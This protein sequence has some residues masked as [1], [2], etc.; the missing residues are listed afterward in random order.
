[1]KR[2]I[3]CVFALLLAGSIFFLG[4]WAA[5]VRRDVVIDGVEVGG[6][7]YAEA[8][9]CVRE[10]LSRTPFVLH[11]PAGNFTPDL[12]YTDDLDELLRHAKK[13][14]EYHVTVRREL[15]DAEAFVEDVCR[16]KRHFSAG[17]KARF[18]KKWIFLHG[19]EGRQMV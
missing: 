8:G 17:C 13:G 7:T 5:K 16:E 15:P 9:R 10:G 11:T 14:G 2:V 18:F 3:S 1:M 19:G 4:G 12:V 6:L